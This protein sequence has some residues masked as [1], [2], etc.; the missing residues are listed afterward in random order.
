[1]KKIRVKSR[2]L[3]LLRWV[4]F[5]NIIFELR[6]KT[7]GECLT[8]VTGLTCFAH[9]QTLKVDFGLAQVTGDLDD[10]ACDVETL[11]TFN[12]EQLFPKLQ[13]LLESDYFRFYKVF[14]PHAG[15]AKEAACCCS[16]SVWTC[17][18]GEPE[19]A[20]SVLDSQQSLRSE[21]L[22]CE[23]LLSCEFTLKLLNFI[24]TSLTFIQR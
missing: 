12:N 23:A 13:T 9:E 5:Y 17:V 11:D 2:I 8:V 21:G 16:G 24:Y 1:M 20:V 3:D 4:P 7:R 19:Q 6:K 22:C 10:C 14:H 18:A 15:P